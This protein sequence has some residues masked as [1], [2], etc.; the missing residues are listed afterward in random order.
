MWLLL[1]ILKSDAGNG[2]Q[3]ELFHYVAGKR[4]MYRY[5]KN[6]QNVLHICEFMVS[7]RMCTLILVPRIRHQTHTLTLWNDTLLITVGFHAD[8]YMLLC[9]FIYPLR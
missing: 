8:K 6:C 1:I 3:C 7:G 4:H 5:S 9:T 2:L